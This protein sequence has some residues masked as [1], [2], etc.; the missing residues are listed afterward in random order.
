MTRRTFLASAAIVPVAA[1]SLLAETSKRRV[2][3]VGAGAFGGWTALHLQRRGAQVT[4]IDAWG[5]GNARSSSGG[6]SRV[7]RTIYGPDRIYVEMVKRAYELWGTLDPSLYTETG[8]LW[9]HRGDDSYVRSALPI[10]EDLGFVVDKLTISEAKRRYPKIDFNG[11][12][13]VYF[14][15]KA[16][17]L[18]ARRA[19]E[20]VRDAFEKEGGT[21]RIENVKPF[22]SRFEADAYV[23]ACGPW[24]GKL[25]PDVIGD[26]VRP[27][28]Q[29][30]HYFGTPRGSTAYLPGSFP[31]WIDF[32]ERIIYGIPDIHGRGF[33]VADDTRGA[34]FDPT[35]GN[36]K[37][38]EGGIARARQLL[39]ERF[40]ELANAPLVASEVCQYENSPDGH[41]IIDRHPNAKNVWLVGG[42]SGHGFKLSPVVGEIVADAIV[43]EKD[44]PKLF[45]LD[46]LHEMEK[47]KTQFESKS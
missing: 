1:R 47:R 16:G 38:S 22:D 18:S 19:C 23:Y 41:L 6:E 11:V 10:V 27:T 32:G 13:S 14:E 15:R 34:A 8:A 2:V 29:E 30:V 21:F 31:I 45:R 5:P 17:A 4:L 40:P 35:D 44:V 20:A 39:A 9:M 26:R 42:G 24:L 7:I 46:R 28:R 36:R 33:K 3:V 25:F 43:S 37:P 12:K